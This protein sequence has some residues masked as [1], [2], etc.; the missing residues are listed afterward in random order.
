MRD[1]ALFLVGKERTISIL[2]KRSRRKKLK[3]LS[4]TTIQATKLK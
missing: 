3:N 1:A 4:T 2:K